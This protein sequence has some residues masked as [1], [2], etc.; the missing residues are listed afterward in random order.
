MGAGK[1]DEV[2]KI[3][4]S[5]SQKNEEPDL[6]EF[7]RKVAQIV[8]QTQN[9]DLQKM[10]TGESLIGLSRA[11]SQCGLFVP[12]ELTL[13]GK[14]LLQLDEVGRTL[15]PEFDPNA[16]I[17]RNA[18]ELMTR[19][20]S[21]D[22]SENTVFS[23]ILEM[24][25]FVEALPRRVN[26][27]MDAVT[28]GGVEVKVKAIDAKMVVDGMHKIANRITAGMILAALIIGASLLMRVETPFQIFGYPG[29]AILCFLGAAGGGFWLVINIFLHDEKT[30]RKPPR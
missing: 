7:R 16:A 27:I 8:V 21:Q 29:L 1:S 25:N 4:I 15:E 14:T 13:L 12:S 19:K 20:M 17:N 6:M 11:A 26:R 3:I 28:E 23:S 2:G 22:H 9:V 18:S 5:I 10:K 30:L 24:K